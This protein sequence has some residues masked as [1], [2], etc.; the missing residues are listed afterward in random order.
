LFFHVIKILLPTTK[1]EAPLK[2]V[3]SREGY[4]V[5]KVCEV[6]L[7]ERLDL[8][9]NFISVCKEFESGKGLKR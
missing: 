6:P 2:E 4:T 8:F 5:V 3:I 7:T 1:D 9:V